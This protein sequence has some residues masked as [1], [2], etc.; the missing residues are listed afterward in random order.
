[1]PNQTCVVYRQ[2]RSADQPGEHVEGLRFYLVD[3][4]WRVLRLWRAL[5]S[6]QGFRAIL[7]VVAKLFAPFR[8]MY[9][10]A[11]DGIIVH[12]GWM[13][14]GQSPLYEVG[15]RD[16][17]IGPIGTRP[18]RR[19]SGIASFA[20]KR[21]MGEMRSRGHDVFFIHTYED[22]AASRRVIAKCGFG[23]PIAIVPRHVQP[24][25]DPLSR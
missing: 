7:S 3:S 8:V 5:V 15:R 11:E 6:D 2:R 25:K 1:M 4:P 16:V 12:D 14:I 17:V 24:A 21:A 19:G 20:L 9:C 10:V 23:P 13:V 22:N 18:H